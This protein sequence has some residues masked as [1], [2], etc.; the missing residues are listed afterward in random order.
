MKAAYTERF[1]RDNWTELLSR[2]NDRYYMNLEADLETKM[3]TAARRL[4]DLPREFAEKALETTRN[5]MAKEIAYSALKAVHEE[6]AMVK[7][8]ESGES[9][10]GYSCKIQETQ[11][12]E[13]ARIRFEF[14][15]LQLA[16]FRKKYRV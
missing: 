11:A 6:M 5:M 2:K 14:N 7:R 3:E 12:R 16:D 4:A 8:V 15:C 10:M 9:V 1:Y 13:E